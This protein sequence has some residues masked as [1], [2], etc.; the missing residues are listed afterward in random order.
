VEG[1]SKNLDIAVMRGDQKLTFLSDEVVDKVVKVI[2][3]EKE[4]QKAK[5]KQ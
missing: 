3:E 2:E 5:P 1:T 4:E